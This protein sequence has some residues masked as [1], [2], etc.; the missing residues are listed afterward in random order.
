MIVI[1]ENPRN[2][3]KKKKNEFGNQGK[4]PRLVVLPSTR[5]RMD[6]DSFP[7]SENIENKPDLS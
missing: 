1:G 6:T 3:Q 5:L 7:V 4:I 2:I